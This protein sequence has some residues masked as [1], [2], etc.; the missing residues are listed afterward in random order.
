ME[1]LYVPTSKPARVKK[2]FSYID[3]LLSITSSF[4]LTFNFLQDQD[5]IIPYQTCKTCK[6]CLKWA[7]IREGSF[8]DEFPGFS[9]M[10]IVKYI[11]YYYARGYAIDDVLIENKGW[12]QENLIHHALEGQR[13]KKGEKS[14]FS[15]LKVSRKSRNALGGIYQFT[16]ELIADRVVRD[17][18][19]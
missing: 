12:Y 5:L 17:I 2:T 6:K 9:L 14:K 16:R 13:N 7:S 1:I 18:K 11:F 4:D 8:L 19:K 15:L 10:E 3:N